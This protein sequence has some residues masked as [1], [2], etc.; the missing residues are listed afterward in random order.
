[1]KDA[2]ATTV[3]VPVRE[4]QDA[5][6]VVAMSFRG[7]IHF[8]SLAAVDLGR[9]YKVKRK[10]SI[11]PISPM[12]QSLDSSRREDGFKLQHDAVERLQEVFVTVVMS[13]NLP[14]E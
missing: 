8:R 3:L 1:M 2:F 11:V 5:L 13:M 6:D 10:W 9:I 14:E 12:D 7:G 4:D